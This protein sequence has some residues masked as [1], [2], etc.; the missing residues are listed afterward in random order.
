MDWGRFTLDTPDLITKQKS[1]EIRTH[2]INQNLFI[3]PCFVFIFIFVLSTTGKDRYM[4]LIFFNIVV[5][6]VVVLTL[7][8][9]IKSVVTEHAPVTLE[10]RNTPEKNT[11]NPRSVCGYATPV[12]NLLFLARLE[13]SCKAVCPLHTAFSAKRGHDCYLRL[14]LEPESLK[15]PNS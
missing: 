1:L 15:L 9:I 4:P 3:Y 8:R 2:N 6:V 14:K 13:L 7:A 5:V 10:L 12:K 11:N